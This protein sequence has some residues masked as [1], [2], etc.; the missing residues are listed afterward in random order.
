MQILRNS[1]YTP[2]E[3]ITG[4]GNLETMKKFY[5]DRID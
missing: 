5:N 1:E 2:I 3:S 4:H